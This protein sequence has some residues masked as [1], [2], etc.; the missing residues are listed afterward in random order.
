MEMTAHCRAATILPKG[1]GSPGGGS[2]LVS[3]VSP[4]LRAAFCPEYARLRT[5]GGSWG[6]PSNG[7]REPGPRRELMALLSFPSEVLAY[8][9]YKSPKSYKIRSDK[10]KVARQA[11][12]RADMI[13]LHWCVAKLLSP[14]SLSGR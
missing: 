4:E 1:P 6:R 9:A 8:K 13:C 12:N 11:A 2:R 14:Q 10:T 5:P 3:K 7:E